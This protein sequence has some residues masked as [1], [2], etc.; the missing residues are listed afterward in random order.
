MREPIELE[1]AVQI[2]AM[3]RRYRQLC[4]R[5]MKALINVDK[6][7]VKAFVRSADGGCGYSP[8]GATHLELTKKEG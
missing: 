7:L 3:G 5:G 8:T 2:H 6:A 4:A 1:G